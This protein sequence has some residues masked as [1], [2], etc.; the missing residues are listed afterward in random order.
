VKL[1][2]LFI[3]TETDDDGYPVRDPGSSRNLASFA[4]APEF[5]PLVAAEARRRGADHVRQTVGLGDGA[6]WIWNL[7]GNLLR[8]ATQIVDIYHAPQGGI[9]ELL[10]SGYNV[11]QLR[12]PAVPD[13]VVLSL[14]LGVVD[15]QTQWNVTAPIA[16]RCQT[17]SSTPD[18]IRTVL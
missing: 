5:G 11:S 7:A 2:C 12:D 18:M 9:T 8:Q 10:P 13:Y 3:Q 16:G 1:A 4:P 17:V 15:L 14:L 6:V